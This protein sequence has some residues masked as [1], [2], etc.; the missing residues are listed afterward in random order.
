M[1]NC[2]LVLLLLLG[3]AGPLAAQQSVQ[4]DSVRV[5]AAADGYWS[6]GRLSAVLLTVLTGPIAGQRIYLGTNAK[7]PFIYAI[8]LGGG[9]GILPLIDLGFILFTKDL[10]KLLNNPN[11]FIWNG[12]QKRG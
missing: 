11:V 12:K 8:T 4:P 5:V 6:K 1:R 3:L 10:G 2:V 7:V 9:L